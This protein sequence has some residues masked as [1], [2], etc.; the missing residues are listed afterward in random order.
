MLG[1]WETIKIVI[2]LQTAA[3]W[4]N[5]VIRTQAGFQ[6]VCMTQEEYSI[7]FIPPTYSFGTASETKK[8]TDWHAMDMETGG[9]LVTTASK[10]LPN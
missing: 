7:L 10:C 9:S 8:K 2:C 3:N 4:E 5:H 6:F 1:P